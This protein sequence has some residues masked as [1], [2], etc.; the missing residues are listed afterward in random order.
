MRAGPPITLAVALCSGATAATCVFPTERDSSVHVSLTKIP[1]LFR[2]EDTVATARAWQMVG[3]GDSQP[4]PNVVFVWS[5]SNPSVATVDGAG[6]IVG[7]TSGTVIITAAAANFDKQARAAADT[8]RVAAPLEIDSL[9]P[10]G[11]KYGEILSIYG[12]GVDSIFSAS[13]AGAQLIRV[14]FAD[15]QF[16]G[17]TERSKWW[18]P[19]PAH[20]DTLFFLGIS[21]TNGIFGFFHGDTTRVTEVDLFEPNDI[22]P[23]TISLNAPPPFAVFPTLEF[24]NPALAFEPIK[25]PALA[26]SDWYRFTH[27]GARDVTIILSAP[28]IARTFSTFLTDSLIWDP[29]KQ[30]YTI[31]PDSWTFGPKSH[32]CHGVPWAPAASP[33]TSMPDEA[34]ADSTIVAFKNLSL[35][36]DFLDAVAVYTAQGRYGLTVIT[37]YQSELPAD[38]HEDDNSCN[39][40][41]SRQ[42]FAVPFRDTLAIENPHDVDWIRFTVASL[43]NYQFR[44]HAFPGVHP[45]SLKDLD[46]YVVKV[47][48]P[49]DPSLSIIMAD[50]AAGSDVNRTV[51]GLAAGSYYA[52]VVDFAGT[53]TMYE[54]CA[55][56][57]LG[58]CSTSF[59]APPLSTG[60]ST[61]RQRSAQAPLLLPGPRP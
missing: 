42:V 20:T 28:Q 27:A 2:G 44:L 12:V 52:V 4:I 54:I 17:G 45:D 10:K 11:V 25:R 61:V 19:P 37:G 57:L 8:L 55:A 53:A 21:G 7:V 58:S 43:G 39:A 30:T 33:S 50:T 16:V 18:V 60:A 46:L 31:G 41:D 22:I 59:P 51:V 48:N 26:G 36:H 14:P 13:L 49:G 47:P 40:A 15:T 5:S 32:V 3:P 9:R 35:P 56:P 38:S 34:P 6:H 23:T 24:T 29:A 1:I